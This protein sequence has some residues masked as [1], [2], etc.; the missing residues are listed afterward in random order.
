MFMTDKGDD[1]RATSLLPA[2]EKWV[3]TDEAAD[4]LHV[5][6]STFTSL[7][8]PGDD[9]FGLRRINRSTQTKKNSARGGG[10]LWYKPDLVHVEQLQ[11]LLAAQGHITS[12]RDVLV[13][14]WAWRSC[15]L[16]FVFRD[17]EID[18]EY[19]LPRDT[20]E[21]NDYVR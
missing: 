6:K 4:I 15:T 20:V 17:D 2:T 21:V 12:L 9:Y 19:K 18:P 7:I 3:T 14:Y 5:T 10:H 1:Y 13:I 11:R 8:R 16:H